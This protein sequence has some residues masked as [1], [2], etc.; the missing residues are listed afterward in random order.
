M[1]QGELTSAV[2]DALDITDWCEI[3]K[4]R[5]QVGQLGV[6]RVIEPRRHRYSIVWV[7][8]VR[9]RRVVEDDSVLNRASELRE[10]K[11]RQHVVIEDIG[12]MKTYFAQTGC[13][14]DHFVN[15]AHLLQELVNA[16]SLN[17][18]DIVPVVLNLDRH[19]I[20]CLLDRL[21]PKRQL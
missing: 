5:A 3:R 15:L 10:E 8:D 21:N 11:M 20:I 16:W 2:E 14:Y 12:G 17:D 7:E 1:E 18:V 9:C 13:E 4:E 6:M 19:D